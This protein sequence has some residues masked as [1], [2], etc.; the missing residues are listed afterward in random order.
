[1][2]KYIPSP[3]RCHN[4]QENP[5]CVKYGT[6]QPDHSEDM[7]AN[8]LNCRNCNESLIVDSK[9]CNVWEKEKEILKIK[10]IQNISFPEARRFVEILFN[11]PAFTKIAK[12]PSNENQINS[13]KN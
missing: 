10:V 4:S 7:C 9:L 13:N 5:I 2:A 8:N 3:R 1:M 11:K 12:T 6:H